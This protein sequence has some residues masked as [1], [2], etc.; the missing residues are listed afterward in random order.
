M[1]PDDDSDWSRSRGVTGLADVSPAVRED[2]RKLVEE[3]YDAVVKYVLGLGATIVDAQDAAQEAFADAWKRISKDG[4][5]SIHA[6]RG[7]L[8]RVALRKYQQRGARK[9]EVPAMPVPY[10]PEV[11]H[12]DDDPSALSA[13]AVSVQRGLEQMGDPLRTI[14]ELTMDGLQNREIFAA[15]GR[16]DQPSQAELQW[17]EDQKKK[18]RTIMET[19]LYGKKG[20]RR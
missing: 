18:A 10:L 20:R 19:Y 14:L 13:L 12:T 7:W 5:A 11:V 17:I 9:T 15:L 3:N 1:G 16:G 4:T 6:P 8:R 2:F